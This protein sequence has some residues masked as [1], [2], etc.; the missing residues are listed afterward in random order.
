MK[1]LELVAGATRESWAC[2]IYTLAE[3]FANL[4]ALPLRPSIMP[5]QEMMLVED[6]ERRL[7]TVV[8]N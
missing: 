2:G 3:M 1:S 7:T 6:A 8:L 4:T 5:R